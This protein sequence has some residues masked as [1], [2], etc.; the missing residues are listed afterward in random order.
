[1]SP[2]SESSFALRALPGGRVIGLTAMATLLAAADWLPD[3]PY[4][5]PD[6]LEFALSLALGLSAILLA[7]HDRMDAAAIA[8]W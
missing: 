1:M 5:D 7:L 3:N 4:V 2:P 8:R 6:K